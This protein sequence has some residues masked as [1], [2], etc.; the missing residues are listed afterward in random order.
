MTPLALLR[1]PALQRSDSER[2][3]GW[4]VVAGASLLAFVVVGVGFYC[5]AVLFDGLC[6]EHGWP[7]TSVALATS[8]FFVTTG[9]AGALVGRGVDRVG[10]RVFFVPG[11]LLMAGALVWIGQIDA[12][13]QLNIA[14]PL[15][16]VGFAMAGTVPNNALVTRWFVTRRALAMSLSQSGVSLGGIVLVP[17]TTAV[18]IEYGVGVATQGLAVLLVAMTAIVTLLLVRSSPE[19][20]GQQPDGFSAPAGGDHESL[21]R[22]HSVWSSRELLATRAFWV[23]VV[24]F[25][26]ILFCQ[27]AT[28][29]HQLAMLR[30]RLEPSSAALAVSATAAASIVARLVVGRF[31]DRWNKRRLGSVLMLIQAVALLMFAISTRPWVMFCASMVFGFTIGNI[32]MLQSLIVGELFGMKSFG[33]AFGLLQLVTQVASGLGPYLLSLMVESLGGYQLGMLPLVVLAVLSAA[34][35]TRLRPLSP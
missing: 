12:A 32:F 13:W 31:A 25:S 2:F 8:L 18:I 3:Y 1:P 20:V 26:G 33:K 19:L 5:L 24:A 35:L 22:Q 23:T 29:M 6:R 21:A 28:A 34:V 17:V 27:V 14:Y 15:L 10:P 11:A 16:A 9:L 4:F 30:E 7:P